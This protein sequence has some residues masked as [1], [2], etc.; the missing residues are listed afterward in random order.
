MSVGG[1]SGVKTDV[2]KDAVTGAS[3]RGGGGKEK[4]K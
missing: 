1:G 2:L 4:E 3:G